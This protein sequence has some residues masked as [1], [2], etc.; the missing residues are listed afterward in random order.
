MVK[1]IFKIGDNVKIKYGRSVKVAGGTIK[2]IHT[3]GVTLENLR[4]RPGHSVK[5]FNDS[6]TLSSSR[7][8]PIKTSYSLW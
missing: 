2:K 5:I 6:F 8:E 4:P 1:I 7:L 3:E